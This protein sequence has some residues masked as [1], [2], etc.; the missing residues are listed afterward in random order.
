[1]RI[2][3]RVQSFEF[4]D[5]TWC[6][7]AVRAGILEPLADALVRGGYHRPVQSC[8]VELCREMGGDVLDH[9]SGAGGPALGLLADWPANLKIRYYLSDLYPQ[10]ENFERIQSRYPELVSYLREPVDATDFGS[11]KRQWSRQFP[12][13]PLPRIRTIHG[14]YHQFPPKAATAVLRDAYRHRHAL[15]ITEPFDRASWASF[16]A[17][18]RHYLGAM[19]A[20]LRGAERDRWRRLLLTLVP[21]VPVIGGWDGLISFLRVHGREDFERYR[22]TLGRLEDYELTYRVEAVAGRPGARLVMV[23]G[24]PKPSA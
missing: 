10:W 24:R 16:M 7:R 19:L 12:D 13:R 2:L 5:L 9:C 8:L 4:N 18:T 20:G 6:P 22:E 17:L 15:L 3:R 1:M 11:L 21:V 23:A 14:A